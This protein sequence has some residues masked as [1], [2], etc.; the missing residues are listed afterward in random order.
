MSG[1][2]DENHLIP[3]L[4]QGT[5]I[6]CEALVAAKKRRNACA[7]IGNMGI[8][9]A[10]R[11]SDHGAAFLRSYRNEAHAAFREFLHLQGFRDVDELYEVACQRLFG[12]D[13]RG[14][15]ETL[16]PQEA[17]VAAQFLIA[18]AGDSRGDVEDP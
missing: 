10:D 18:Y 11:A 3:G 12:P 7:C 14:G 9:F 15:V 6:D 8:E 1:I 2:G 4:Y 17:R 13:N 5:G 16:F